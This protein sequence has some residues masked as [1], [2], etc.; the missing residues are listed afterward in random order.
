M[1]CVAQEQGQSSSV[2]Y[3]MFTAM[4]TFAWPLCCVWGVVGCGQQGSTNPVGWVAALLP[5]VCVIRPRGN[6]MGCC[7]GLGVFVHRTPCK[8]STALP[9]PVASAYMC[10]CLHLLGWRSHPVVTHPVAGHTAESGCF[11][12][13]LCCSLSTD[14]HCQHETRL[15]GIPWVSPRGQQ[16]SISLLCVCVL[17]GTFLCATA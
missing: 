1:S 9:P 15:V 14:C 3:C 7:V 17:A 6:R 2:P 10:D 12:A 11:G 5:R 13:V 16:R 4:Q 8:C